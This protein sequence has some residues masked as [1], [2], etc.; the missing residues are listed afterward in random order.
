MARMIDTLDCKE[1]ALVQYTLNMVL[2]YCEKDIALTLDDAV[3]LIYD[4]YDAIGNVREERAKDVPAVPIE[5]SVC[6]DYIVCLEDGKKLKMLKR[7]LRAEYNMS[8]E[9]YRHKWGLPAN[10]PMV[11]SAYAVR[12]SSLARAAGLGKKKGD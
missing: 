5:D 10:Y 8:P 11:A 2:L 7:H 12:R 6:E 1:N 9:E 4:I 3:G